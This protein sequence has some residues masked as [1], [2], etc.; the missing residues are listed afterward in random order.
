M[1]LQMP[2]S[3]ALFISRVARSTASLNVVMGAK[4]GSLDFAA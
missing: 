1:S 4:E 2:Q 3:N